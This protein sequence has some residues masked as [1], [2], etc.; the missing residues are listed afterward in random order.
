MR[1][2]QL[3][4]RACK[5]IAWPKTIYSSLI[6]CHFDFISLSIRLYLGLCHWLFLCKEKSMNVGSASSS[7]V[8]KT[9]H[10]WNLFNILPS[11][12]ILVYQF[13]FFWSRVSEK[14]KL[15]NVSRV[16]DGILCCITH[17]YETVHFTEHLKARKKGF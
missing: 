5:Q 6:V 14:Y 1:R 17:M 4:K 16:G 2:N 15:L 13:V 12:A 11:F 7:F 8:S 3:R 10:N 9:D